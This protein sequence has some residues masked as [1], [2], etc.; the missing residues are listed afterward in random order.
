MSAILFHSRSGKEA[1]LSG[2]ERAYTGILCTDLA[3]AIIN[4]DG[5]KMMEYLQPML[6]EGIHQA[7]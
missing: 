5:Y 4:P 7:Q 3:I 2:S 6:P 1:A